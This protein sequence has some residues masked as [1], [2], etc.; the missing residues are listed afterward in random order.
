MAYYAAGI[1][2]PK[3]ARRLRR[4]ER[5]V[6]DWLA[7]KKRVP[8]WVPEVLRLQHKEVQDMNR[9]ISYA[10]DS[11]KQF[12]RPPLATVT[13]LGQLQRHQLNNKKPQ[14]MTELRLDDFDQVRLVIGA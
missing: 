10:S 7:G 9:H 14:S 5:T 3:L 2:I 12:N 11:Y 1:P 6:K 4:D 13:E 8:W